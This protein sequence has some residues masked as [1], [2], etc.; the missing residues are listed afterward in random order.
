MCDFG[1]QASPKGGFVE[2]DRH[3]AAEQKSRAKKNESAGSHIPGSIGRE[4]SYFGYVGGGDESSAKM[5]AVFLS[6]SAV[7]ESG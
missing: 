5:T 4:K 2:E 7:L 1:R 3:I 6:G